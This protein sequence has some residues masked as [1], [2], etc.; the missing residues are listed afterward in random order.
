MWITAG[1]CDRFDNEMAIRQSVEADIGGLKKLIDDTNMTRINIESEIEAVREELVFL[2]KN[3]DDVSW[4]YIQI[5][6][7]KI[8]SPLNVLPNS[9]MD[10]GPI[11][12]DGDKESDLP[13]GR[14][15]GHRR[16]QRSGPGP[17][18]GGREG[19]LWEDGHEERRRSQ[20]VAWK[21]GDA[22]F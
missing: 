7:S 12:G 13:V 10:I 9:S 20:T 16:P 1:I 19:Q 6:N 14:S 15:S 17:G 8:H 18:H 5:S 22:A 21:S 4:Q 3:H 11:G 2:K